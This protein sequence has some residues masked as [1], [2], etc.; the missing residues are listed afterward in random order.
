MELKVVLGA[1]A[2]GL[3]ILA[4]VP[5]IL[6]ILRGKT[7]PHLY[8]WLIWAL[9]TGIVFI[10]QHSEGAG[11]GAWVTGIT[12]CINVII[13]LL[14]FKWGSA[15]ITFSDKICL[16]SAL[17]ILVLWVVSSSMLLSIVLVT[18]VDVLAFVP[19]IRKIL[20]A[21][22][23]ETFITY[24]ISSLRCLLGLMAI[25][26]YSVVTCIYPVAMLVMYLLITCILL[27]ERPVLM[28]SLRL[29]IKRRQHYVYYGYNKA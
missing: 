25:S 11:A 13:C 1:I 16:A 12:T 24:P 23:Q 26:N 7:K 6:D 20:K 18:I 15:D 5:Y 21:P 28:R 8:S 19:T 22:R 4:F 9:I 29:Q 27:Y 3:N 10:G 2:V 14:A 17:A